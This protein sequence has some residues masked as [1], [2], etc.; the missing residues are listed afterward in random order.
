M[1]SCLIH[2]RLRGNERY[3]AL[4]QDTR[5]LRFSKAA[6]EYGESNLSTTFSGVSQ[7]EVNISD[8]PS[9]EVGRRTSPRR[10][11]TYTAE[12]ENH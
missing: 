12:F 7:R 3:R 4:R 1:T 2:T 10:L 9:C 11:A 8:G 5:L 6:A